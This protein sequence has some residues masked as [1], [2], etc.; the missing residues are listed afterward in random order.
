MKYNTSV[1]VA[2]IYVFIQNSNL[3]SLVIHFPNLDEPLG[4]VEIVACTTVVVLCFWVADYR[5][6][7]AVRVKQ[8]L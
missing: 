7:S 3:L 4:Y 8:R 6:N 2:T 1:F 5:V